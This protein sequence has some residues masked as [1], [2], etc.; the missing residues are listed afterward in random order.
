MAKNLTKKSVD[1]MPTA[2]PVG[3]EVTGA[4]VDLDGV[5]GPSTLLPRLV[6]N[7]KFYLAIHPHQWHVVDGLLVPMLKRLPLANGVDGAQDQGGKVNMAI[8]KQN[9]A[10]KGY[11]VIPTSRGPGGKSY[12][13]A[14]EV[15]GGVHYCTVFETARAG[16]SATDFDNKALHDW[17]NAEIAAGN[18]SGP[19]ATGLETARNM[20][21][22][23]AMDA[24]AKAR[25][26][27]KHEQMAAELA[28]S[29]KVV[30]DA[31][32]ARKQAA[33]IAKPNGVVDLDD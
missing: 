16:E 10:T 19:S 26:S 21:R 15:R 17:I 12:L 27:P 13:Q 22:T 6:P 28:T 24:A 9:A 4:L 2:A 20:L 11:T 29:L 30:E 18:L 3:T 7:T 25:M 32:A 14:I 1:E 23:Q 5:D 8:P 31:I 33:P